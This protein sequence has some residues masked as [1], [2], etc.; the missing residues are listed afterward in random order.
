MMRSIMEGTCFALKDNLNQALK[1]GIP[2]HDIICCGGCSKSEI[3]LKIKASVIE[4]EIKLPEVNLGAP[5]GLS[6]INAAYMGEYKSPEEA[7]AACL[8]IRKTVEPVK[9]WIEPYREMFDVYEESY[10]SLKEQFKALVK[11]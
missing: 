11:I 2:I 4:K 1:I 10:R 9:E 7:S 6:Y 3:W 8:K 5:G